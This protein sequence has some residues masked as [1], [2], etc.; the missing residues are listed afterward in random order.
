MPEIAEVKLI[1]DNIRSYLKNNQIA[2][3]E[4]MHPTIIDKWINRNVKGLPEFTAAILTEHIKVQDVMTKGK[5]CWIIMNTDSGQQWYAMIGFGMSGNIRPEPTDEYLKTYR[6]NGKIISREEYLKHCHLKINYK[7]W[8]EY[9]SP[10]PRIESIYYHDIRRFGSWTFTNDVKVLNTKLAKLGKD[11]LAVL[12][13]DLDDPTQSRAAVKSLNSGSDASICIS[14]NAS[15]NKFEDK[16]IIAAF[17][18]MNHQN[19]C[20]ALMSQELIAGVG[21]YIKAETL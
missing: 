16:D 2:G 17:R 9:G 18:I 10:S 20:K 21:S 4:I 19:I 3:I 8:D 13:E 7:T 14:T 15:N 6:H 12:V 1:A 11:P 5:F